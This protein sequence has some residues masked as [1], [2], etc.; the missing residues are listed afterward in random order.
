MITNTNGLRSIEVPHAM[1]TH[2]PVLQKEVT[3]FLKVSDGGT[4]FDGTVGLGGH[5]ALILNASANNYLY[6]TDKD[7]DSLDIARK[8]LEPFKNRF[9]LFH[10]DFKDISSLPIEMN[11]IDG[12]LFDLGVSSL[13]L[14]NPEKGFSYAQNAPLDMR[15]NKNQTLS[16]YHVVN[17]YSYNQLMDIF[18]KYGEFKNPT[19]ILQQI[20]YHRKNKKIENTGELKTIIR[21]IYPRQKTMD[22]LSRIFQAVRIEVN[23]ELTGLETFFLT[24]FN[25]MKPGSRIVIISFHSLED[26]ITKTAL[27]TAKEKNLVKIL[28]KKPLMASEEEIK[29]NPRARSAKLRAAEKLCL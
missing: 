29:V 8:N 1:G 28:T 4:F 3:E 13:Q 10:S 12:F 24:I 15:M 7:S 5:S 6:G 19:K 2:I 17:E 22:P 11:K 18:Q 23:Q 9:T 14:D 20:I 26:R 27:K 21:K 16:A 25:H